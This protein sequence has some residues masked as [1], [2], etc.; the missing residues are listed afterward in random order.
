VRKKQKSTHFS[1]I[2]TYLRISSAYFRIIHTLIAEIA[3]SFLLMGHA[4]VLIVIEWERV[5]RRILL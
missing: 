2:Q 5:T 4:I 3:I 1:R